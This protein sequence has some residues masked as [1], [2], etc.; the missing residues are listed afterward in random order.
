[1]ADAIT[2]RLV[3]PTTAQFLGAA[4]ALTMMPPLLAGAQAETGKALFESR[5]AR[6]HAGG[7]ASFRTEPEHMAPVLRPGAVHQHRFALTDSQRQAL[8]D[9]LRGARP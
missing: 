1:V 5:C 8:V 9:Y 2:L 6:C 7:P 4:A 3:F